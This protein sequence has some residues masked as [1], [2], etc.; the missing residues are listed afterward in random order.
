[1]ATTPPEQ[2]P[3]VELDYEP[4]PFEQ[5]LAKHK[6][7]LILVALLTGLGATAYY[8]SKLWNSH[9]AEKSGAA[10][11][12]AETQDDFRR[13][14]KEYAGKNAGGNA[15][16]M[17][18]QTLANEGK[19]TEAIKEFTAFAKDFPNH[20]LSDLALL[21]LA[22]AYSNA[23]DKE[24]AKAK[25]EELAAKFPK[26][27]YAPLALLRLGD[28][29]ALDK[30]VEKA[31][32][33]Y[34]QVIKKYP[35]SEPFHSDAIAHRDSLK[36]KDPVMIPYVAPVPPPPPI[37]TPLPETAGPKTDL[38][39]GDLTTPTKPNDITLEVPKLE[40][41]KDAA[42]DAAPPAKP[43]PPKPAEPPTPA[44]PEPAA[45]QETPKD[46]KK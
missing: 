2:A 33:Y 28:I 35:G 22:D 24:N 3:T 29:H 15:A 23:P 27:T 9:S 11:F 44:K 16:L 20:P 21:R 13:V 41:P 12:K 7:K 36:L 6:S 1:M 10:F 38:N 19:L 45:P 5:A 46:S 14:A 39:V 8:A 34:D 30:D 37:L 42:P 43:E 25:F 31:N 18:A 40:V 4:S 32:T 17:V 26:S